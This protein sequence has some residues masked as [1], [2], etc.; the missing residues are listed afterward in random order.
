MAVVTDPGSPGTVC[1]GVGA[2]KVVEEPAF[3]IAH[4]VWPASRALAAFAAAGAFSGRSVLELGA[5]CGLVGLAAAA[6]GANRVVLTDSS[7][8]VERVALNIAANGGVVSRAAG[9]ASGRCVAAVLEWGTS[10]GFDLGE[11]DVIV[12][13]DCT[14]WRHLHGPLMRTLHK[15]AAAATPDRQ[16]TE[17]WLAHEWRRPAAEQHFF[18]ALV[19]SFDVAEVSREGAVSVLR[20]TRKRMPPHGHAGVASGA[21]SGT[22]GDDGTE[23]VGAMLARLRLVEDDLN[24]I[25]ASD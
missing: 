15:L 16:A 6:A 2:I 1:I 8:A 18:D 11:F 5:G 12:A 25:K 3:G 14:Y 24:S 7:A 19:E 17:V 4:Q 22:D 21:A 20:A 9:G 13:S 10:G 23:D